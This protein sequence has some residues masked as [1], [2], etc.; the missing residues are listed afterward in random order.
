MRDS[1]SVLHKLRVTGDWSIG[2]TSFSHGMNDPL[3]RNVCTAKLTYALSI[4]HHDD[5]RTAFNQLFQF[6]RNHQHAETG[7]SQFVDHRLD[8][9]L[10]ADVDAASWLIE[11]QEPGIAAEPAR[12]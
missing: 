2:R 11:D 9:T 6:R 5:T 4:A 10:G 3:L 8:F 1:G 7:L 12:K